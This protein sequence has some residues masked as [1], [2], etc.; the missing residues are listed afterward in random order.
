MHIS[1]YIYTIARTSVEKAGLSNELLLQEMD[2]L[3]SGSLQ[4]RKTATTSPSDFDAKNVVKIW[5]ISCLV[6]KK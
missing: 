4:V 2:M 6:R 3:W 1:I 5:G